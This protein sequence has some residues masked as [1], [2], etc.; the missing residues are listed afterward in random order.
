M[1]TSNHINV[2]NLSAIS[3]NLGNVTAGSL[4][5]NT[6]IDVTTD[7]SVG[8]NI[9]LKSSA[10]NAIR[11]ITFKDSKGYV[12]GMIFKDSD[13][14]GI[15]IQSSTFSSS[16]ALDATMTAFGHRKEITFF[17]NAGTGYS[18]Q[19]EN[20]T[21]EKGFCGV[22]ARDPANESSAVAGVAVNFRIRKSFIPSSVTLTGT[23][24]TATPL[25]TD[26][27]E[28]GFWLYVKGTGAGGIFIFTGEVIIRRKKRT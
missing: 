21:W 25:T 1:I 11:G 18:G 10:P 7:L 23:S 20:K 12:D 19:F 5:S 24:S 14:G 8:N 6:I 17:E 27:R 9:N 26:I 13:S 2:A 4:K 22:G 3:A 15:T 28:D 16:V